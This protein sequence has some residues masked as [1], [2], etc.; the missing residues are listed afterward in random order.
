MASSPRYAVKFRRRREGSTNYKR[1]LNLLRSKKP[2]LVIRK[3]N[4]YIICQVIN[5]SR[6]GDKTITVSNSGDLKKLGWKHSCNNLPAAYLTGYAAGLAAKKSKVEEAILD[7]GLYTGTK[8]SKIY[9]ALKGV[10]DGGL[11]IPHGKEEKILP[12]EDRIS[13]K[14]IN[15]KVEKDFIAIK[16]K[17]K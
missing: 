2:R 12:S 6:E 7:H 14:H 4:K 10:I 11:V 16:A 15:E 13:G 1:R 17:I 3:S 9:S 8:G 5:Y